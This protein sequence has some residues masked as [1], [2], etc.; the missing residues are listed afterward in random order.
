MKEENSK[1][2]CINYIQE[3]VL[4]KGEGRV[5]CG[6]IEQVMYD[7]AL[8]TATNREYAEINPHRLNWLKMVYPSQ[9][10]FALTSGIISLYVHVFY[11]IH[12]I[13][14]RIMSRWTL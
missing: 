13:S 5:Y 2:W 1:N 12:S 8:Y 10:F 6:G 7:G 3:F 9:I 11:G 14:S 4:W